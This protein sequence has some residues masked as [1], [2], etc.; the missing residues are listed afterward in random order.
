MLDT[1]L[2]LH[3]YIASFSTCYASKP[4]KPHTFSRESSNVP[5]DDRAI[6]GA[7]AEP[8][9]DI[10]TA[11]LKAA[12]V[13][14]VNIPPH[15]PAHGIACSSIECSSCIHS[16]VPCACACERACARVIECVRVIMLECVRA[17]TH[18]VVVRYVT[19]CCIELLA[20][21]HV[22]TCG[23][24]IHT[25]MYVYTCACVRAACVCAR[26][27]VNRAVGVRPNCVFLAL[28]H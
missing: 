2:R 28:K 15:D 7:D 4:K 16:A 5:V 1:L 20:S 25:C 24:C 3:P 26:L 14:A 21:E 22:G 19:L 10:P 17:C 9:N 6:A 11:S 12:I 18:C 8:G 23:V 13:L 27:D